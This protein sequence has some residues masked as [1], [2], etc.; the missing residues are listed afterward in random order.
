MVILVLIAQTEKRKEDEKQHREE[1]AEHARHVIRYL[2]QENVLAALSALRL[3]IRKAL[4][5][6][7]PQ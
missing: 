4:V 2:P 6:P 5:P 7:S 1:T 3:L